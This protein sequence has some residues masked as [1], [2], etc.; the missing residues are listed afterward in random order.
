MNLRTAV[1]AL[2][3]IFTEIGRDIPL[4]SL[5]V[6]IIG[7]LPPLCFALF[8]LLAP[9]F[10]RYLRVESLLI[11][12]LAAMV[13]GD[14]LRALAGSYPLL[15]AASGLTFAGMGVGNVLLPP[16]V[17]KYFPDRIGLVTAL[18]ATVM[19]L[20]ALLPPLVAVPVSD[21]AGW[22]F[23]VGMW[24][25]LGL[26]A[27]IPWVRLL[28]ADRRRAPD[29]R[30]SEGV[31]PEA[32]AELVGRARHSS[33]SRGLGVVFG[34]TALNSYACFAWLPEIL[35]DVAGVD[36]AGAG[37]LLSLYT[38]MGIPAS[39][40]IPIIAARLRNVSGIIIAGVSV[41]VLGY[42]GLLLVPATLPWLWVA[43]A[44]AGPLLFPLALLLIN[45]RSRTQKGAV[46]LSGFVQGFG[47]LIGA[48]GPLLVGVLHQL[49]GAWTAPLLFLLTS[50]LVIL[51]FV[52]VVSRPRVIEDDW[53]PDRGRAA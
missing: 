44:G 32:D 53:V 13:A 47:Y 41:Y 10:Q 9:V 22:R 15:L 43:F 46:A 27:L 52:R 29:P 18:Y 38:G 21:A 40:L 26:V 37:A 24:G 4:S 14:A 31:V 30:A 35:T 36:Q 12:A 33:L 48:L 16:M 42:L 28:S 49:T 39:L 11:F 20:F 2:S 23:A 5:D 50:A 45:K 34:I 17:K 3:P 7:T 8:G 1:A 19:A 6:G 51:L 25:I